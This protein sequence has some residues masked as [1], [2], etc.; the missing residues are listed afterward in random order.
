MKKL[1]LI[2]HA[3]SSWSDPTV[4]DYNRKLNKRGKRDAPFMALKLAESGAQPDAVI[5]SPAKRARKTAG[6]MAS[7]VGYP[8]NKIK[9]DEQ[10][11][12][13]SSED[14]YRVLRSIDDSLEQ[15]FFVGHNFAITDLAEELTG[16]EIVNIPTSG[17]VAM[18]CNI[19]TWREI[20][21]GC[22]EILFFDYPK[23]YKE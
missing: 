22:A 12:S 15:I 10:I 6:F 20:E 2:R 17:I 3:K 14:L 18:N 13:A 4:S 7:A 9:Y 11:Y 16:T 23:R 8:E 5:S 19:S 1:F 21:A